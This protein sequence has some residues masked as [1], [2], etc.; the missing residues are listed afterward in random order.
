MQELTVRLSETLMG[1][2]LEDGDDRPRGMGFDVLVDP[3]FDVTHGPATACV[4]MSDMLRRRNP[5]DVRC[6]TP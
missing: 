5:R 4:H 3:A 1:R 2:T 6:C